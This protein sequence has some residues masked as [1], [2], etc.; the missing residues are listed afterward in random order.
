M[1]HDAEAIY[2]AL[3]A[4]GIAD[5]ALTHQQSTEIIRSVAHDHHVSTI[6]AERLAAR[7]LLG[8]PV[9][10]GRSDRGRS[11]VIPPEAVSLLEDLHRRGVTAL[12]TAVAI[13]AR[14][15]ALY[16]EASF[17]SDTTHRA[18]KAVAE[19]VAP[20]PVPVFD[21]TLLQARREAEGLTR[22]KVARALRPGPSAGPRC[23]RH[24]AV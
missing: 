4:R 15:S 3:Q 12:L 1:V 24:R 18:L 20:S 22:A 7:V 6:T 21:G 10:R 8:A 13:H 9:R 23:K 5:L 11:R 16:P 17:T 19:R 14:L 2:A